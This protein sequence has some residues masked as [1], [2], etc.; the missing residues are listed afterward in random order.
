MGF[1]VP[2]HQTV[3]YGSDTHLFLSI[4][5]ISSWVTWV[6]PDRMPMSIT[7]ALTGAALLMKLSTIS[8]L[9]HLW[10][11]ARVLLQARP[12]G[13]VTATLNNDVEFS[14]EHPHGCFLQPHQ[15]IGRRIP[16]TRSTRPEF[17]AT[18][19]RKSY[20]GSSSTVFSLPPGCVTT[21]GRSTPCTPCTDTVQIHLLVAFCSCI[22]HNEQC[23]KH[24]AFA[25]LNHVPKGSSLYNKIKLS[26]YNN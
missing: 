11:A 15:A 10:E 7:W 16:S 26:H 2:S 22:F 5:N 25:V 4:S 21:G 9:S 24:G 8:A 14:A 17:A 18:P 23:N 12:R 13:A 3:L 1:K 19:H 6:H 20:C